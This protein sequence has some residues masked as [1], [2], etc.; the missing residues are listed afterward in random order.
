[1]KTNPD[2]D[3]NLV[4]KLRQSQDRDAFNELYG[5]YSSKVFNYCL[6]FT[7]NE[8]DAKDCTQ[9]IFIR[10]FKSISSFRSDAKFYTWLY[11][12][13]INTCKDMIRKTGYR[14]K[15]LSIVPEKEQY[16]TGKVNV[17]ASHHADPHTELTRKEMHEAF[18]TALQ[19]LNP[20]FR[21]VIILRDIEDRSYEEISEITGRKLGTIRSSIARGRYQMAA[22]LK[23]FR[24]EV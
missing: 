23:V 16:D 17:P 12:I 6:A 19:K 13:M 24:N 11:R 2:T 8:D 7:G 10:V 5:R 21:K 3:I 1:M 14:K 15:L 22:Y 4:N 20:S 18:I 9:E